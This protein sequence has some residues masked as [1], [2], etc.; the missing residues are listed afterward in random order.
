MRY[1]SD[2][3]ITLFNATINA[4]LGK[5]PKNP[6]RKYNIKE[7]F[8]KLGTDFPIELKS[9]ASTKYVKHIRIDTVS[10]CLPG[11]RGCVGKERL[12]TKLTNRQTAMKNNTGIYY[13]PLMKD[14]NQND[15]K[16]YGFLQLSGK[17]VYKDGYVG[18]INVPIDASGVIGLRTGASKNIKIN[19]LQNN[20]NNAQNRFIE[21][22]D[23]IKILLLKVL[24]IKDERPTRLEMINANFNL[25]TSKKKE[26]PSDPEPRPHINNFENALNMI[27]TSMQSGDG[28]YIYKKPV[29]QWLTAQGQPS[30]MKGIFKPVITDRVYPTITMSA[31]GLVEIMG[32]SS[33][34][35]LFNG[36]R[37]IFTAFK[38]VED[39][40][41]IENA[42]IL[43]KKDKKNILK[44]QNNN[45]NIQRVNINK[46]VLKINGKPCMKYSKRNIAG[47]S[48][49]LGMSD[50][51]TK[52]EL[53]DKMKQMKQM[54]TMSNN[55]TRNVNGG[56]VNGGNVNGGN[57]N[58]GNVNGG[59]V[60]GG[61]VNGGNVNGRNVNGGNVNGRNVNGR[62]VNG[63]NVNGRSSIPIR[64][65]ADVNKMKEEL[66]KMGITL[67]KE[68]LSKKTN[69]NIKTNYTKYM[70][71]EA[72]RKRDANQNS[73][74]Y[75]VPPR[76]ER[77]KAMMTKAGYS[78]NIANM[79]SN[80]PFH[81][82]VNPMYM[83]Y[84]PMRGE[85]KTW[86]K[87]HN[88]Y[89]ISSYFPGPVNG[90]SRT[91]KSK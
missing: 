39:E 91:K 23:E 74:N 54:Y 16:S 28:K 15:P 52:K 51:G 32:S 90:V 20:A 57:V 38:K 45:V 73:I 83:K 33:F 75:K 64:L 30:V 9:T 82:F 40:L 72:L 80:D 48:K 11:G 70:N 21:M 85:S 25:Y 55:V 69:D 3:N 26:K 12:G 8:N 4:Y 19:P 17:I 76:L 50:R 35:T 84:D 10:V 59:N 77:I 56:N 43:N 24:N 81:S 46:D 49:K 47:F 61:N 5:R 37:E 71:N 41:N 68:D 42:I 89:K 88:V 58:G 65:A 36:Y 6:E 66:S 7:M 86:P 60:N 31:Y 18:N 62:N 27:H 34:K 13:S 44:K 78:R 22:I 53:C 63:R 87:N 67:L 2:L 14:H 79:Y 29:K 1:P